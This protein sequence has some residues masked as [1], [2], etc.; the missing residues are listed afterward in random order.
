MARVIP[1]DRG[2]ANV[3]YRGEEYKS[4]AGSYPDR[5]IFINSNGQLWV[6]NENRVEE[7]G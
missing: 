3:R 7:A 1:S 2:E 4:G 5:H 6:Q